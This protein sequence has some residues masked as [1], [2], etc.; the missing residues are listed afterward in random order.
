MDITDF[1][2]LK[3][4]DVKDPFTWDGLQS[5]DVH[6][7][8]ESIYADISFA[9]GNTTGNHTIYAT[10]PKEIME[11]LDEFIETMRLKTA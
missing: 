7:G 4:Y 11:K 9:N 8:R 2:E 5:I 6:F 1:Q 10:T 3:F